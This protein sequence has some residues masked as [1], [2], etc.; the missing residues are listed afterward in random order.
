MKSNNSPIALWIPV[1][2]PE[3]DGRVGPAGVPHITPTKGAALGNTKPPSK[4]AGQPRR[5]GDPMAMTREA[6]ISPDG[7]CCHALR[8]TLI[9][10]L[11]QG[12]PLL[13]KPVDR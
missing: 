7:V 8:R 4:D 2:Y 10:N 13:L 6:V 3:G 11:S 5:A 1:G 9:P 12:M